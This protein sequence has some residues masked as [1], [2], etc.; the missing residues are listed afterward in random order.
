MSGTTFKADT[1]TQIKKTPTLFSDFYDDFIVNPITGDL[2]VVKNE[3]SIS[4]SIKNLIY[5]NFGERFFQNIGSNVRNVLF[6]PNDYIIQDDLQFHITTT[7]N[8]YEPRVNL[9]G[10]DVFLNQEQDSVSVNITY[11]IIN[12]QTIQSVNLILTRVR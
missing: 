11:S 6:E 9:L 10:V 3:K 4:Q 2:A 1:I 7:I 5:T 12:T 8:Q